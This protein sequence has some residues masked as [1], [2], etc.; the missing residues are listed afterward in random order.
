MKLIAKWN[1]FLRRVIFECWHRNICSERFLS[2]VNAC[3]HALISP[4]GVIII[5]EMTSRT[6][7]ERRLYRTFA[8]TSG[9]IV[10]KNAGRRCVCAIRARL[11]QGLLTR[12]TAPMDASMN[13]NYFDRDEILS[14]SC[15]RLRHALRM[16]PWP[17]RLLF[18]WQRYI[19]RN[20]HKAPIES[21]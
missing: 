2:V 20:Y 6:C 18:S 14:L 1:I 3:A 21:L 17:K 11:E 12:T 9:D 10:W 19:M 7:D 15:C 13:I 4:S 8:I 5:D 16:L